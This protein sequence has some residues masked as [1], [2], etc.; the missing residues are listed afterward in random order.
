MIFKKHGILGINARNL[1][2]IRPYNTKKA[3]RLADDKIKTKKF[4]EARDIPVPKTYGV[5]KSKEDLEKFDFDT[6]PNSFVLKPN[7]GFGGEGIIPVVNKRGE[8]WIKS[9]GDKIT[10]EEL[11]NHIMDILDGRFSISNVSDCAFF[12]HLIISHESIGKFAY[13]GLPDIRVVVHNLIP[14]MAM[15]RLP[16]EESDGKANLH[17]GAIGTGI[18]IA[19]GEVTYTS[20]KGKIIEE[21]PGIGKINGTKIPFWDEILMIASK[22]Q[23]AT[24]LG[25]LAADI[26]ID[27]NAGPLL[28]EINA[29]AGL[30]VQIAN[31][32]PLRKRLERIEGVKVTTPLKGI[33]IAKDMFGNVLEKEITQKTGKEVIGAEEYIEIILKEGT[34]KVK[35]EI[36]TNI[37]RSIIDENFAEE[38]K[39]LDDL[40]TYDDE[41]SILK[42]KFSIRGMRHQTIADVEAIKNPQYKIII[43]SRDLKGFLIDPSKRSQPQEQRFKKSRKNEI[44]YYEIDQKIVE[45]SDK[46]KLLYH[47]RPL[48][49]NEEKKKFFENFSYNPKFIYPELRF[50]PAELSEQLNEIETD[51]STLGNIFQKKKEELLEQIDLVASI[52]DMS[53]T[54]KS[55][56]LFGNVANEFVDDAKEKLEKINNVPREIEGVINAQ[57][58]KNRFEKIFKEYKLKNW[59]AK[60]KENLVSDCVAGKRNRLLLR[61]DATFNEERIKALIVHEI[62]THILTAENGK[63]QPYEIFNRGLAGYL[64]TQEGLAIYNMTK[65]LHYSDKQNYRVFALVVAI[66]DAIDKPFTEV[67][68]HLLQYNMPLERA[69]RTAVKVKRGLLDTKKPGCFTKD[70]IYYTGFK[71]IENFVEDGGDLKDLYIGKFNLHDLET[72]KKLPGIRPAKYLPVWL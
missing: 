28:I 38:M 19:K 23:L 3:V 45:A 8:N 37:E 51:E 5:I 24:N 63:N 48:N 67:F 65:R 66:A 68:E 52:G 42:L 54:E 32:A 50:D 72:I 10:K 70:L 16:T 17:L 36:N 1:L 11:K 2:Y 40:S 55:V 33:R 26:A 64:E 25:Y 22:A 56:R 31:L 30:G 46:I 21:I 29:R 34:V 7:F 47:L 44:N 69:F 18:D 14:V 62:E 57:E 53:F 59:K 71:Q 35:A 58:V 43:G 15:L 20:Y 12:E 41:K 60:L 6:L 4:L 9:S 39:L 27:K 49:L 13:E 61:E